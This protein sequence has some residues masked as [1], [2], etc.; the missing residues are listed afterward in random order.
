MAFAEYI[1]SPTSIYVA[2]LGSNSQADYGTPAFLGGVE[3]IGWEYQS[4]TDQ[5]KQYGQVT[6]GLTIPTHGTFTASVVRFQWEV[7]PI[8]LG[9]A[10]SSTLNSGD[11]PN[12]RHRIVIK[13]GGEGLPYFGLI[14]TLAARNGGLVVASY[15]K[16]MLDNI[17]AFTLD[18]N[19]F[20]RGDMPMTI[21]TPSEIIKE[22][23]WIDGFE[24]AA[25]FTMPTTAG[26]WNTYFAS[27]FDD[28]SAA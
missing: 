12:E 16:V 11:S 2:A 27:F 17:P 9:N 28:G 14:M 18:Q 5:A 20:R 19:Q 21:F 26:G 3:N 8:I 1:Y 6:D 22:M 25:D 10:G 4:D 7:Q 13:T 24:T 23:M 15:P